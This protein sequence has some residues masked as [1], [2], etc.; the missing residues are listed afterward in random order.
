M[1]LSAQSIRVQNEARKQLG[2]SG[3]VY[4][5]HERA[6]FMGMSYGLSACGYDVRVA[7]TLS[8]YPQA[9]MLASTFEHFDLPSYLVGRV[10]DKSS[11][12]RQGLTVQNTVLEPGWDGYLTLELTN[13]SQNVIELR[14]GQPIAQILFEMLDEPTEAPYDGKYNH[15]QSGPQPARFEK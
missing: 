8:L 6:T 14:P 5:F 9:F 2:S 4:P 10:C 3:L 15:Q 12:A 7:E 13:H 1:I 11:W